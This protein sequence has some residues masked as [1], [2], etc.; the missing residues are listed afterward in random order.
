MNSSISTGQLW[1]PYPRNDLSAPKQVLFIHSR[2]VAETGGS[3]GV[4]DLGL[5]ESAVARPR[6]TFDGK[7][8]YPELFPPVRLF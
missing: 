8:L 1:K 3:H 7:E 5:L 4:R 6:A 2:L